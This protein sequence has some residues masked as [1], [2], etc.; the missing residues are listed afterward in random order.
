MHV[1]AAKFVA[2]LGGIRVDRSPRAH[3]H[4]AASSD[5][6]S[7]GHCFRAPSGQGAGENKFS[8]GMSLQGRPQAR[9]DSTSC[10]APVPAGAG[11]R[12]RSR[13]FGA[14][15]ISQGVEQRSGALA[16]RLRFRSRRVSRAWRRRQVR[17][18][19]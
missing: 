19:G 2:T 15:P 16:T 17:Q 8:G 10:D 4:I 7:I 9:K 6:R 13:V 12:L 1:R 14:G 5:M 3:I 11:S 18:F